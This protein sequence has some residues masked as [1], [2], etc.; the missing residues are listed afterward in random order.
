MV[1]RSIQKNR[2]AAAQSKILSVITHGSRIAF[3]DSSGNINWFERDG[4]TEV[5]RHRIGHSELPQQP[6]LFA[7]M[8]ASDELARKILATGVGTITP[9]ANSLDGNGVERGHRVNDDDILFW[10][11]D[12]LGILGFSTQPG[13]SSRSFEPSRSMT[14]EEELE[15]ENERIHSETMRRAL[16]RQADE[17]RYMANL[18]YGGRIGR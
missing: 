9:A 4:L 13:T 3:S 12:K 8:P 6:S 15:A 5:R 11:G 18:G 16:E 1:Q 7:S 17:V 2:Q 14:P 10:T